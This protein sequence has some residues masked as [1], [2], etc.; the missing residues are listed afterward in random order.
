MSPPEYYQE[1]W[2][3]VPRVE[4]SIWKTASKAYT[5]KEQMALLDKKFD[6]IGVRKETPTYGT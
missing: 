3:K 4:P 6:G 1:F 2:T 5:S